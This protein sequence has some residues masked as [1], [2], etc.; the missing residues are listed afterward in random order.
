MRWFVVVVTG[1]EGC[2][3]ACMEV[4]PIPGCLSVAEC[5][6]KDV[7]GLATDCWLVVDRPANDK[8]FDCESPD[9]CSGAH[10]AAVEL[11]CGL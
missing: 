1:L 6:D 3:G 4:E 11:A 10:D 8:R 5:C 7:Q 2:E 9:D